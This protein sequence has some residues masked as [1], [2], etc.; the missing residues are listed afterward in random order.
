LQF[1][2]RRDAHSGIFLD[3]FDVEIYR[4]F[5]EVPER[6]RKDAFPPSAMVPCGLVVIWTGEA[7]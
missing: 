7:W 3:P 4:H 5:G 2:E 1:T 6:L